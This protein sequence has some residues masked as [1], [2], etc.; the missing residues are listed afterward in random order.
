MPSPAPIDTALS[1][2]PEAPPTATIPIGPADFATDA[3]LVRRQANS[4]RTD[5]PWEVVVAGVGANDD[6]FNAG[7]LNFAASVGY[8]FTEWFEVSVRQGVSMTD[9]GRGLPDRWDASSL[10][11]VD[12]HFPLGTVVPYVGANFGYV[13]GDTTDETLAAG[14]EAGIRIYVKPETFLLISAQ[15]EFFFDSQD[16][17]DD[18]F[19]DGTLLYGLGFGVRF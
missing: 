14:P 15:Y 5:N 13:Y 11:A 16:R 9:A 10:A 2:S 8:Y 6:T 19:E 7:G 4:Q 12:F 17:I 3:P 1:A 18:A